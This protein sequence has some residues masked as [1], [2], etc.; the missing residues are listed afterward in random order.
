MFME[1]IIYIDDSTMGIRRG[2]DTNLYV[3]LFFTHYIEQWITL[4][5][6]VEL[7]EKR[8]PNGWKK[9]NLCTS[10]ICNN[11]FPV[12]VQALTQCGPIET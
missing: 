4:F 5:Y 9:Y 2:G 1:E 11:S 7:N 8:L 10:V 6:I 3:R 12:K